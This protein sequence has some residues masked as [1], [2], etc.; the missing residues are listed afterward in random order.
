MEETSLPYKPSIDVEIIKAL[1]GFS[2]VENVIKTR[3][4]LVIQT[5]NEQWAKLDKVQKNIFTKTVHGFVHANVKV[6]AIYIKNKQGEKLAHLQ[7]G[8]AGSNYMV[9]ADKVTKKLETE[10][11]Q[12]APF[13][14]EKALSTED[15]DLQNK[16]AV[17]TESVGKSASDFTHSKNIPDI[18]LKEFAPEPTPQPVLE[19]TPKYAALYKL[20]VFLVVIIVGAA[21]YYFSIKGPEPKKL[22]FVLPKKIAP[23]RI[24]QTQIDKKNQAFKLTVQ[25]QKAADDRQIEAGEKDASQP[26]AEKASLPASQMALPPTHKK[27]TPSPAIKETK[28]AEPAS[29]VAPIKEK[30][31]PSPKEIIAPPQ[32]EAGVNVPP[33]CVNV[34]LCKLKE[35]ADVV[36]K[37]LQKKGYAP[38]VD[39]ITVKDTPWYRVTLGPFKT[40]DEAENYARELQRKE[41]IKGFVVK[42]K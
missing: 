24:P 11:D 25:T 34:S 13:D 8:E 22:S 2:I 14:L 42:K 26:M 32:Q 33:Y 39:T 10:E 19:Q 29:A 4:S 16:A 31:V 20:I 27:G 1:K 38:A 30:P 3:N 17:S 41:N 40:Q 18:T 37:D 6:E 28:P 36:I 9:I 5:D 35:S 23:L 7:K 12:E 15:T 21:G